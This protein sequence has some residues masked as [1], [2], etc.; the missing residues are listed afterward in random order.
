MATTLHEF[1]QVLDPKMFPRVLQIQSGIYCQGKSCVYEMFG[2]ECSLSTGDLLKVIDIT[3]TRFTAQTSMTLNL[4]LYVSGLFKLLAD[5]QPYRSIQEIADSLKISS[6][7]LSQPVFLSGSEIQLAQ[8]VIREGDSF[9][10]TTVTHEL[11]GGRVQCELLH[12]EPKFCFSLSFSQ[13]GHFTECQDNQ[14]YTLKEIAEWKISK[15]R[16]R[17]VTEGNKSCKERV[18]ELPSPGPR[19]STSYNTTSFQ[20]KKI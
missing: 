14:F 19:T 5:S 3:I 4:V 13:Q 6:H 11:N 7:R 2:R 12:R 20:S 17:T 9:R 18:G 10:I 16:K 1:T 15:G 8:G